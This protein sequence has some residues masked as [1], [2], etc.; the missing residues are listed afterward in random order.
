M[1]LSS[2]RMNVSTACVHK[3]RFF[4]RLAWVDLKFFRPFPLADGLS[5]TTVDGDLNPFLLGFDDVNL[6]FLVLAFPFA[7]RTSDKVEGARRTARPTRWAQRWADF[8]PRKCS[9]DPTS[10]M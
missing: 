5:R 9:P 6:N 3:L 2:H 10:D 7:G 4:S 1:Q 8:T